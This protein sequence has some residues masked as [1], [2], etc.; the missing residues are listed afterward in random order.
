[1]KTC[2]LDLP[3]VGQLMLLPV[4]VVLDDALYD[5]N[6]KFVLSG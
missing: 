6:I 4:S 2:S 1:M 3:V 5:A